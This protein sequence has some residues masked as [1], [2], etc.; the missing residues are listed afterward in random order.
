MTTP[1]REL[2]DKC[3]N[4]A[5]HTEGPD[6]YIV[7]NE[8]VEAIAKTHKQSMCPWCELFVIWTRKAK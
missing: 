8:W 3:P 1:I 4:R 2:R 6:G 7:W 5:N